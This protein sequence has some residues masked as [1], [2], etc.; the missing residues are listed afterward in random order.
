MTHLICKSWIASGKRGEPRDRNASTHMQLNIDLVRLPRALI[1][2]VPDTVRGVAQPDGTYAFAPTG[3]NNGNGC[4]GSIAGTTALR[5]DAG[6]IATI[7]W[8]LSPTT[9]VKPANASR[10]GL[11]RLSRSGIRVGRGVF[12]P[13]SPTTPSPASRG[14]RRH[15]HDVPS[16]EKLAL[17]RRDGPAM[18]AEP[19]DEPV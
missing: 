1:E 2:N 19:T 6:P 8:S 7:V 16:R 12:S 18:A 10:T 15:G 17:L 4:A 9:I 14:R 5:N 13:A 3:I 11:L